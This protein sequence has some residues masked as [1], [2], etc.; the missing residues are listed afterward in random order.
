MKEKILSSA[1]KLFLE[2]GYQK[3]TLKDIVKDAGT[4]VGNCYFYYKNKEKILEAIIDSRAEAIDK[5]SYDF[6]EKQKINNLVKRIATIIF[7]HSTY[8]LQQEETVK[9]YL[10]GSSFPDI[11]KL[12]SARIESHIKD[13]EEFEDSECKS[14]EVFGIKYKEY[15]DI[16]PI[17]YKSVFIGLVE[18][19][20]LDEINRTMEE[21]R[22]FMIRWVLSSIGVET[23]EVNDTINFVQSIDIDLE[24]LFK[25]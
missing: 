24:Q 7:I 15:D 17:L 25:K 4:S 1:R 9:L 10:M 6:L 23:S 19:F 13:L 14:D 18:S 8:V 2:K 20:H 12:A 22:V 5:Y 11:R 3:T 16:F 21:M